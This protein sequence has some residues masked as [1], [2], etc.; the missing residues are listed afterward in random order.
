MRKSDQNGLM[1]IQAI[2]LMSL[3]AAVV[4]GI[5]TVLLSRAF[6]VKQVEA[7]TQALYVAES[8]LSAVAAARRHGGSIADVLHGDLAG[9]RWEVEILRQESS[10]LHLRSVGTCGNM[11][12]TVSRAL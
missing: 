9:C 7:S 11:R 1:L 2:V 6:A 5:T 4:G 8:G 3:L 12:R 10:R